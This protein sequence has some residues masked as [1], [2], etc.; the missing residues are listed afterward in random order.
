M[1]AT[2]TALITGTRGGPV[3][4]GIAAKTSGNPPG[5]TFPFLGAP[6]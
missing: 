1:D 4:S 5:A 6:N 2:Y 3:G